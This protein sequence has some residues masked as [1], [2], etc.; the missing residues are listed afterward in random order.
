M[1]DEKPPSNVKKR[2]LP[3]TFG[4]AGIVK[5]GS[6]IF[7]ESVFSSRHLG[8][9]SDLIV[10]RLKDTGTNE[11]GMRSMLLHS[12]LEACDQQ[13]TGKPALLEC[14]LD[15]ELFA[16]TVCFQM[17]AKD[18][19]NV[20]AF[21]R[22]LAEVDGQTGGVPF[23]GAFFAL[24]QHAHRFFI[25]IQP[26]ARRFELG[27]ILYFAGPPAEADF[28][29]EEI[30][31]DLGMKVEMVVVPDGEIPGKHHAEYTE[32]GD[33]DYAKL[34]ADDDPGNLVVESATGELIANQ[35]AKTV[36]SSAAQEEALKKSGVSSKKAAQLVKAQK[37]LEEAQA[38]L[39]A[40]KPSKEDVEKIAGGD[41]DAEL[42]AALVKG[43]MAAKD[44]AQKVK[45][46]KNTEEL[47]QLVK[48]G[49]KPEE[50]LALLKGG[51]EEA[52]VAALVKG[53]MTKEE[54]SKLVKGR[55]EEQETAAMLVKGG[56]GG[57]GKAGSTMVRGSGLAEDEEGYGSG[58]GAKAA[59]PKPKKGLLSKLFGGSDA[60]DDEEFD[61]PEDQMDGPITQKVKRV[62]KVKKVN[63]VTQQEEIVEEVIEEVVELPKKA[64]SPWARKKVARA[65]DEDIEDPDQLD[66]IED[67][68][69]E[70]DDE[71]PVRRKKPR[72]GLRPE[73]KAKGLGGALGKLFG[74]SEEDEDEAENNAAAESEDLDEDSS[75]DAEGLPKKAKRKAAAEGAERPKKK[76]KGG[77]LGG[78]LSSDTEEDV[79]EDDGDS[80]ESSDAD[81][82]STSDSAAPARAKK[83][84]KKGFLAGLLSSDDSEKEEAEEE[85]SE[86]ESSDSAEA[87]DGKPKK[88]KTAALDEKFERTPAGEASEAVRLVEDIAEGAMS[89]TLNKLNKEAREVIAQSKSE[90]VA[91]WVDNV[92]AEI[93]A[94]KARLNQMGRQAT[95]SIKR[96][97]VE[98]KQAEN[99]LK[100]REAAIQ[101]ELKSKERALRNKDAALDRLRFTLNQKQTTIDKLK[102]Q[103]GGGLG[104]STEV[105]QKGSGSVEVSA[106]QIKLD[107]STRQLEEAKKMNTQLSEKVAEMQRSGSATS[108]NA[109]ELKKRLDSATKML[110][111]AKKGNDQL[112]LQVMNLQKE[113]ATLKAEMNRLKSENVALQQAKGKPGTGDGK[114][115]AG[116]AGTPAAGG[117]AKPGAAA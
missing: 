54:A 87:S 89:N 74:G 41:T 2:A 20:Q 40:G 76:K 69:D 73:P 82:P 88:K 110:G 4:V 3:S 75:D 92:M 107:R 55:R 25:R 50:A 111:Q 30:D 16:V 96:K 23:E 15:D 12:L 45:G 24:R 7:Y 66:E 32:L 95:S 11:R 63:P 21:Q 27:A 9:I 93:M 53:G 34:L 85:T 98:I 100:S 91:K 101:N 31:L 48:S 102:T 46:G 8:R 60:G 36:A 58:S 68:S 19:P 33:L 26:I 106:L 116:G 99:N 108:A 5:E 90:K 57:S 80:E 1:S 28:L 38:W 43:G 64:T 115:G 72:S 51:T 49:L 81:S 109:G 18:A 29:A 52:E 84:K 79:P 78:L 42:V 61:I 97:E 77:L 94:E 117:G 6:H 114:G 56:K 112:G 39:K 14:G 70:D 59:R 22:K 103:L 104:P 113:T 47:A 13:I 10:A 105:K 35:L 67:S 86:S 62:V 71:A 17:D 44:I 37:E 65:R 83:K